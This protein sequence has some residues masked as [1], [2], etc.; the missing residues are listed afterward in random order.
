MYIAV[1]HLH[2][3]LMLCSVVFL[4]VRVVAATA[5]AQFLKRRWIKIAPHVLDTF[6]LLS[7]IAL[8]VIIQQYPITNHWLS[9]KL[10]AL[11]GYIIFGTLALKGQKSALTRLLY[12]AVSLSLVGYMMSIA[13]TKSPFPWAF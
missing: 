2:L 10:L 7:A 13:I 1:K 9:A 6:L 12:L 3:T 11:L 5:N 4:I 8:M